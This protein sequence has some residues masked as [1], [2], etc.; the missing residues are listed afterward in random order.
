MEVQLHWIKLFDLM[1]QI[2]WL[3]LTNQSALCALLKNHCAE[4]KLSDLMFQI[5][6]LVLTNQSVLFLCKEATLI[7]N[8]QVL[9]GLK[10]SGK[11]KSI[12]V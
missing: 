1:F 5:T 3:V 9:F 11:E 10:S 12:I 6:W 2:T 7:W 4:I 8:L